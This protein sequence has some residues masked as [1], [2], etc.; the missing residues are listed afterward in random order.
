MVKLFFVILILFNNF[1][2]LD[3]YGCRFLIIIG[4]ILYMIC[5]GGIVIVF[6]VML[7]NFI[8]IIL[9]FL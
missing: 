1:V 5:L 9:F 3:F 6:V 2:V 4:C 7:D 8:E